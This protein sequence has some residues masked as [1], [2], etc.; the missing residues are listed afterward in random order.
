MSSGRPEIP[1]D[2][3]RVD[4]LIMSGCP[5]TVVA[6][7]IGVHHD[8]LYD[9]VKSEKGLIYSAYSAKLKSKGDAE[10]YY[11]TYDEAVNQRDKTM[12]IWLNKTRLGQKEEISYEIS[13]PTIVA[14]IRE[15][16]EIPGISE[17]D[18]P[19]L[20]ARTPLLDSGCTGSEDPM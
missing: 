8:T 17:S 2:W 4:T 9:R 7:N 1:I 13:A 6:A 16:T 19:T 11:A 3:N 5:G 10:I 12:L 18:E 20:E 15:L 14:A